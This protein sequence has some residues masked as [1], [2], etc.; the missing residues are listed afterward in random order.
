MDGAHFFREDEFVTWSFSSVFA[1]SRF[2]N[3]V[4]MHQFPFAIIPDRRM[5][6]PN[7]HKPCLGLI[8]L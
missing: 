2:I 7:V 4:L 1:T 8:T 3:D 6:S 5:P